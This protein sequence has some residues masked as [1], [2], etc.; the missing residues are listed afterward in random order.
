MR[1]VNFPPCP[2]CRRPIL[3]PVSEINDIEPARAE[4]DI[5]DYLKDFEI[6]GLCDQKNNPKLQCLDCDKL[7]CD[8][9]KPCHNALQS[10]HM[11]EPIRHIGAHRSKFTGRSGI[12]CQKHTGQMK[13]LFCIICCTFLCSHCRDYSHEIC[14]DKNNDNIVHKRFSHGFLQD[15]VQA[16][17]DRK[18]LYGKSKLPRIVYIADFVKEAKKWL[19]RIEPKVKQIIDYLSEYKR[20]LSEAMFECDKHETLETRSQFIKKNF[21]EC[22]K[23]CKAIHTRIINLLFTDSRFEVATYICI[24]EAECLYLFKIRRTLSLDT[25]LLKLEARSV[26]PSKTIIKQSLKCI[27]KEHDDVFPGLSIMFIPDC[28]TEAGPKSIQTGS[29]SD[30]IRSPHDDP[31]DSASTSYS[32]AAADGISTSVRSVKDDDTPSASIRSVYIENIVIFTPIKCTMREIGRPSADKNKYIKIKIGLNIKKKE[33]CTYGSEECRRFFLTSAIDDS[34]YRNE[35]LTQTDFRAIS[36][37]KIHKIDVGYTG[38]FLSG[39]KKCFQCSFYACE[40][41]D[42]NLYISV[43]LIRKQTGHETLKPELILQTRFI[44]V[45]MIPCLYG[46]S[47]AKPSFSLPTIVGCIGNRHVDS[48]LETL[49]LLSEETNTMPLKHAVSF[50][51]KSAKFKSTKIIDTYDDDDYHLVEDKIGNYSFFSGKCGQLYIATYHSKVPP[52]LDS[53]DVMECFEIKSSQLTDSHVR[54]D[55]RVKFLKSDLLCS[56]KQ[57]I[58]YTY[59]EEKANLLKIQKLELTSA[60]SKESCIKWVTEADV[61]I[62]VSK[63]KPLTM[64]ENTNGELVVVCSVKDQITNFIVIFPYR[65]D[66]GAIELVEVRYPQP[67]ITE[68]NIVDL[69][70]SPAGDI[71]YILKSNVR[72]SCSIYTKYL[73]PQRENLKSWN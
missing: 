68:S 17:A 49:L 66:E 29:P 11:V 34:M 57:G 61:G 55:I 70:M 46:A 33:I 24:V 53:S 30:S 13:D 67:E 14:T 65:E 73:M 60:G 20:L 3:N 18:L 62:P 25:R 7:I 28:F 36:T 22:L 19:H 10:S 69:E 72:G 35:I 42:R 8:L 9:C 23:L 15:F 6:C 40:Q 21:D 44:N 58:Y 1:S 31:A 47:E 4:I 5:R 37:Y 59:F 43:S 16:N 63:L 41:K 12:M 26:A 39:G 54:A 38:V 48:G 45:F 27:Q 56:L 71:I 51:T 52:I 2:M 32:N 64:V 50:L